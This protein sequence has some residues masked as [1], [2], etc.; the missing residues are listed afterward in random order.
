[1]KNKVLFF[2]IDR[3]GDYF[4]RSNVIF[5]ITKYYKTSEIICSNLNSKLI[6]KQSFFDKIYVFDTSKKNINK[7]KYII[8]FFYKKYDSVICFDGKNISNI[9]LNTN[10]ISFYYIVGTNLNGGDS[11]DHEN[12]SLYLEFLDQ[13][14]HVTSYVTIHKGNDDY[15]YGS[16]FTQFIHTLTIE[17]KKCFYVRWIQYIGGYRNDILTSDHYGITDI[18]FNKLL[19]NPQYTGLTFYINAI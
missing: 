4:I 5:N 16:A 18:K 19:Y 17:E 11:P 2:S 15:R 13:N 7:I 14:G 9:L 8:N 3:L 1:M 12:E 10:Y 6:N